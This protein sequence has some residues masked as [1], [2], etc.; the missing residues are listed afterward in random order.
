MNTP[1]TSVRIESHIPIPAK[2]KGRKCSSVRMSIDKVM[3]ALKVGDSFIIRGSKD[4]DPVLQNI[5]R[6]MAYHSAKYNQMKVKSLST[7]EG[8]RVWRVA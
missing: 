5:L 6:S 7:P 2:T 1:E 4:A 8:I 3:P